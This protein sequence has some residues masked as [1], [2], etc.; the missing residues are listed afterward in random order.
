MKAFIESRCSG[1]AAGC[2]IQQTAKMYA[3]AY[4]G[5]LVTYYRRGHSANNP[6]NVSA[7]HQAHMRFSMG[8]CNVIDV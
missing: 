5:K 7:L 2:E 8:Y 1:V 4:V 6:G 3:R